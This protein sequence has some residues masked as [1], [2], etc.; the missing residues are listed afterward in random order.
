MGKLWR[1][2]LISA[3]VVLVCLLAGIFFFFTSRDM[4]DL[5]LG[6]P[7]IEVQSTSI[8]QEGR[9][10][11]TCG[12]DKSKNDPVGNNQSPQVSWNQVMGAKSYVVVM[13]DEDT[14]W[15]HWYVD[16][17]TKTELAQ[18]AYNKEYEGPYPPAL[19]GDRHN[20]RIEVFALRQQPD[21]VTVKLD[22]RNSYPE[23]ITE[24]DTAKGERRNILARGYI[25]G[26]YQHGDKTE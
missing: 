22:K 3:G 9:L 15:I 21:V 8:N 4:E 19:L 12:S 14:S 20:Y 23:I 11:L 17:L 24:L 5:E 10:L 26:S 18:G 13:I 6:V 2:R 1:R 7:S 16:N 25:I